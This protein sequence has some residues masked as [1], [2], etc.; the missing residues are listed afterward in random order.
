MSKPRVGWRMTSKFGDNMI[1]SVCIEK[2]IVLLAT[3]RDPSDTQGVET[4]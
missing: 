4:T 3:S 2:R 1:T